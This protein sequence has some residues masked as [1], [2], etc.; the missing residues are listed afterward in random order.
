MVPSLR[1]RGK[2]RDWH[3]HNVAGCWS[4]PV[5]LCI[6]LSG[7]VMSYQWANNL[8]YTLTGNEPPPPQ[9]RRVEARPSVAGDRQG[10]AGR[11]PD[12]AG[13]PAAERRGRPEARG[14]AATP[15]PRADVEALVAAAVQQAPH[16]RSLNLRLA[17]R[18][19]PQV[20]V[21]IDEAASLHPYP[22]SVL[23]LDATSAAVLQW[24]PFASY[25]LVRTLRSWVRPV[26]TGE[27]GGLIGQGIAALASAG[28]VVLV[29]TGLL[30][31]GRR[32]FGR[33]ASTGDRASDD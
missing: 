13:R 2:P 32:F 29:C 25:N 28:G 10:R 31:A 3:W 18:G 1:L 27:A 7:I 16:W 11:Q 23:T 21:S 4:A 20:T 12:A 30:L 33:K 17:Q 24:E 19:A 26:H 8:L 22:R 6:T 15:A 14:E 5:L 9:Q